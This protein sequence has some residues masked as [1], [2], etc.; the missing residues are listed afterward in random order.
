[1]LVVSVLEVHRTEKRMTNSGGTFREA[2]QTRE[3]V[4]LLDRLCIQVNCV[5]TCD[6][7]GSAGD[8][9]AGMIANTQCTLSV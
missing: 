6:I 7:R 2:D 9:D 1:M 3:Q 8:A 4:S 5:L